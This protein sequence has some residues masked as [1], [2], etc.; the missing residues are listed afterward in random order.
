M[1]FDSHAHYDDAAFDES[2]ENHRIYVIDSEI[3]LELLG[4]TNSTGY[5]Y[6][7]RWITRDRG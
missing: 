5:L 2:I 1:I 6:Q 7:F 3:P 4:R